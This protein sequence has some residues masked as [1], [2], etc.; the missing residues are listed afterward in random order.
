MKGNFG[1]SL[2][3]IILAVGITLTAAFFFLPGFF[4]QQKALLKENSDINKTLSQITDKVKEASFV[5]AGY[6]ESSPT[7]LSGPQTLV[8]KLPSLS[9]Q[10]PNSKIYDFI[11]IT[12]DKSVPAVLREYTFPDPGSLRKPSSLVLTTFLKSVNFQYFGKSGAVI[13][14]E[15]AHSILLNLIIS[16]QTSSIGSTKTVSERVTLKNNST[17][18]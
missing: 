14:P 12:P 15:S 17:G 2:L 4:Q 6:P 3:E 8:L 18:Q 16:S 1:L 11:I 7:Y 5:A 9:S 10:G 13:I